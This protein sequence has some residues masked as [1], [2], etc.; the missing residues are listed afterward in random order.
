[1]KLVK[2]F[3]KILLVFVI[4][5]GLGFTTFWF[6]RPT[7][8]S[9]EEHKSEIPNSEYSKFAEVDGIKLHYQEKGAG[10]PLV[11]IHGYGSSTYTW[12]DV[13]EPLSKH[14]R[15][16]AIDLKGFGF[17][18]KPAG[19]YTRLAQAVLVKKFLDKL[20]I[21]RA[22]LAG[23]SM[24]GEVSLNVALQSPEL[25]EGLI[26]IDS[27]G[28][29]SVKG[30]SFTPSRFEIPF[31]GR[32]FVAL[33]LMNDSL[34]RESLERSFYDDT[35]VTDEI[36]KI[37]HLPLQ[38]NYGQRA[39]IYARQQWDLHPIENELSKIKAPTLLIWGKEDFVTPLAGGEKIKASIEDSKLVVLE[40]V[41]HLPQEE[42][43]Q[44]TIEEILKFTEKDLSK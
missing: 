15:V 1:M 25:V 30:S 20:K 11:L 9:F 36:V 26:L 22:W 42:T 5:V 3:F 19:D 10:T 18:E 14:F 13:F 31:V 29:K 33:A 12:R 7:D 16:I 8:V 28:V 38:T 39:A 41:G 44:K 27:A 34:V 43:P 24:G 40:K 6:L 17:S 2:K 21:D 4:V 32:A 35:K 23:N 37:Y